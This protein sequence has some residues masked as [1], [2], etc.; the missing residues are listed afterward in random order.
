MLMVASTRSCTHA[1][2][3]RTS[4]NASALPAYCHWSRRPETKS[5]AVTPSENIVR[6]DHAD[7]PVVCATDSTRCKRT[8]NAGTDRGDGP[9]MIL[10]SV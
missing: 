1:A 9:C 2:I 10:C 7:Y 6:T 8:I 3:L 5:T 4:W